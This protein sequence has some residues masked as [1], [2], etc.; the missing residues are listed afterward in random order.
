M[1]KNQFEFT[2]KDS[3]YNKDT[4]DLF[5]SHYPKKYQ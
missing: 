4:N 1:N 2:S 5:K 3:Q